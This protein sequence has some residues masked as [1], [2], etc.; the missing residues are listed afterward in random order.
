MR[1]IASSLLLA[2]ASAVATHFSAGPCAASSKCCCDATYSPAAPAIATVSDDSASGFLQLWVS[3][4][5]QLFPTYTPEQLG[6]YAGCVEACATVADMDAYWLNYA[7]AEYGPAGPNGKLTAWMT[8]QHAWVNGNVDAERTARGI[9]VLPPFATSQAPPTLNQSADAAADGSRYWR[10]TSVLLAQFDG[11]VDG[12]ASAG[13]RALT[14]SLIYMLG[15]V[16]DLE[17]LNGQIRDPA[18]PFIGATPRA[19]LALS[20]RAQRRSVMGTIASNLSGSADSPAPLHYDPIPMEDKLLDCSSLVT[21]GRDPTDNTVL[22]VMAGQTTWRSYYAMLRYYKVYALS[23]FAAVAASATAQTAAGVPPAVV[24]FASSPGLL[25]SKDDFYTTPR[26]VVMETTNSVFNKSLYTDYLTVKSSLS[27]Q[28]AMMATWMAANGSDWAALF[29]PYNSGTYNNGWAV[30]DVGSLVKG[31]A[32]PAGD[33]MWLV[34]QVPGF[35]VAAD[36]TPVLAAQGYFPGFNIPF[37]PFIY[38]ISGYPAQAEKYGPSYTFDGCDRALIFARNVTAAAPSS[39]PS[40]LGAA[41]V[42]DLEAMRALLRYNDFQHDPLAGG[43]AVLGS[44]SSRGDLDASRPTAFGG[45]DTKAVSW[46]GGM[47]AVFAENG[48]THDQQVVFDWASYPQW[49]GVARTRV[50]D[51]FNFTSA[52]MQ[53]AAPVAVQ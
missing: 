26:L 8:E 31:G 23:S 47:L 3:D 9:D 6:Y 27:W 18:F 22:D 50:P 2:S 33:V 52:F 1:I 34:E 49:A 20:A 4:Q 21:V 36:V 39:A 44:I 40:P 16:G 10:G 32:L 13:G 48:P 15:S 41:A 19:R 5:A 46:A 14:P 29:A 7:A 24:S 51:V 35:V 42:R 37:F 53:A 25:H 12:Y 45:V 38:N 11:L 17:D 43:D 30:V 28:R